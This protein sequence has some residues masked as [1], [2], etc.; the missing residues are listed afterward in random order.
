MKVLGCKGTVR[1]HS[2]NLFSISRLMFESQGNYQWLLSTTY[3]TVRELNINN[4]IFVMTSLAPQ[5]DLVVE[6]RTEYFTSE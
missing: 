2:E 3:S 6:S 1:I 5:K 4:Y